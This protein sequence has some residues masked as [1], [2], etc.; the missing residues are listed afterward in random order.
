MEDTRFE[1]QSD[2]NHPF[3]DAF[4][5]DGSPGGVSFRDSLLADSVLFWPVP[6]RD[7]FCGC[8][9]VT[10]PTFA[11]LWVSSV[12][13]AWTRITP[14]RAKLTRTAAKT[15]KTSVKFEFSKDAIK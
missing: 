8:C 2:D 13:N 10:L 1:I 5:P 9:A 15:D 6:K 11:T 4:L 3:E 12:G 7:T 14:A